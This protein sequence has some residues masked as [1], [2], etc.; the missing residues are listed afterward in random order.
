MMSTGGE[1]AL[2]AIPVITDQDLSTKQSTLFRDAMYRLFRNK[3]AVIGLG[4]ILL[5]VFCAVF[6]NVISPYGYAEKVRGSSIARARTTG[7]PSE[8]ITWGGMSS[9]ASC[10]AHAFHCLSASV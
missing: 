1:Q 5:L 6:A 3:V 8:R 4:F 2:D 9:R 10:T 7:S